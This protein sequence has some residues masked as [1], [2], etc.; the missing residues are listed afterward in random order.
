MMRSSAVYDPNLYFPVLILSPTMKTP[1]Y[2]GS[3]NAFRRSTCTS[4]KFWGSSTASMSAG[5]R[6]AYALSSVV[7]VATWAGLR[8]TGIMLAP[9]RERMLVARMKL[10]ICIL[11]SVSCLEV[12]MLIDMYFALWVL[13][14][15]WFGEPCSSLFSVFF[16]EVT[17]ECVRIVP[18][19]GP[20]GKDRIRMK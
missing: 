10:E 3:P 7:A 14:F 15:I 11:F 13:M 8:I 2:N 1:A 18:S 20:E 4:A 6:R 9:P 12:Y 5:A 17:S 19:E 16:V